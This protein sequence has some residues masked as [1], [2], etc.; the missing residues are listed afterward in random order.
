MWTHLA[1]RDVASAT[2][3][4]RL[5]W[6]N[7]GLDIGYVLVGITLIIAACRL[8]KRLGLVGAGIGVIVQGGALMLLNLMLAAQISR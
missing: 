5:L 6:L 1:P 8:G 3:L 4:D 7:V 2:R